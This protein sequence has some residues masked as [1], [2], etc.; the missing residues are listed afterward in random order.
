[1]DKSSIKLPVLMRGV[2]GCIIFPYFLSVFR[3]NP[4]YK[5]IAIA[6]TQGI[7]SISRTYP[8]RTEFSGFPDQ[9][10]GVFIQGIISRF[11]IQCVVF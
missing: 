7:V 3:I 6:K 5:S 10:P 4:K 1:M 9:L 11:N 8:Y 2:Q